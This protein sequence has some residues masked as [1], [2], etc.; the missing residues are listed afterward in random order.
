MTYLQHS[1]SLLVLQGSHFPFLFFFMGFKHFSIFDCVTSYNFLWVLF[2]LNATSRLF[3]NVS[4]NFGFIWRIFQCLLIILWILEV[5]YYKLLYKQFWFFCLIFSYQVFLISIVY[6]IY[7]V[8]QDVFFLSC[9]YEV[10]FQYS[11]VSLIF[12]ECG[13][14]GSDPQCLVVWLS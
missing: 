8:F 4:Y 5:F 2:L 1:H 10:L 14:G 11:T 12:G 3:W 9:F 6:L 13:T 7:L